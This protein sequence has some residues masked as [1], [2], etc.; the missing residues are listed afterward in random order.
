MTAQAE[1]LRFL[2]ANNSP[3]I[4]R[5][6]ADQPKPIGVISVIRGDSFALGSRL[7]ATKVPPSPGKICVHFCRFVVSSCIDPA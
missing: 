2:P 3:R 1:S 5:M 6:S 7:F 4:A